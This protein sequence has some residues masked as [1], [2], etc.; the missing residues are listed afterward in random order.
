MNSTGLVLAIVFFQNWQGQKGSN[1]PPA[2]LETAALPT[3][4]YPYLV[5]LYSTI[6][7]TTPA[8]TVLPPSRMAKR[9]FSSR[10]IGVISSTSIV[11]L[12]P[13]I[14]TSVPAGRVTTPVHIGRA[15]G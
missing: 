8:P 10:A 11:T 6:F 2:G 12:S 14:T 5:S 9:S 13:G 3:E 1:P 7:A 15:H 4:L